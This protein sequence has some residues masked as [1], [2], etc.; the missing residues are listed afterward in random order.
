MSTVKSTTLHVGMDTH[1]ETISI[2][3]AEAGCGDSPVYLGVIRSRLAE[4]DAVIRRLHS[5]TSSLEF[6]YDLSP[7]RPSHDATTRS[8]ASGPL[9]ARRGAE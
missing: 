6:V 5:K 7:G 4:V 1:K 2:G 8:T 9:P 3:Y